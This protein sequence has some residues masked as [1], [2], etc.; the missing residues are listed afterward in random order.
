MMWI[1]I[2]FGNK[3]NF[4]KTQELSHRSK[5]WRTVEKVN[6]ES[7]LFLSGNLKFNDFEPRLLF[8]FYLYILGTI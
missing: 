6:K 3:T 2:L 4:M 8:W 5:W 1:K 7:E